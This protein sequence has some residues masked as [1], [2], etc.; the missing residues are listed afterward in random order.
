MK[1]ASFVFVLL[2]FFIW[3]APAYGEGPVEA[4]KVKIVV[5]GDALLGQDVPL[6]DG[7]RILLPLRLLLL[8]LGVQDDDEHIVWNADEQSVTVVKDDSQ[9]YLK[10]G[11]DLA[12]V[13]GES[14]KLDAAPLLHKTGKTYIPV[15]F[16]SQ[17]LG[18]KVAWEPLTET[19]YI[20]DEQDYNE[21]EDLL[22][23]MSEVRQSRE[24]VKLEASMNVSLSGLE[25]DIVTSARMTASCDKAS[26]KLLVTL[27]VPLFSK[28]YSFVTY[29]AD[30]FRH[31]YNPQDH[32]WAKTAVTENEFNEALDN[33]LN[34]LALFR[35][36]VACAGMAVS[37]ENGEII[38]RG[39]VFPEGF[40][41]LISESAGLLTRYD[42]GRYRTE[43]VIDEESYE[44]KRMT[45]ELEG[46][47]TGTAGTSFMRAHIEYAYSVPDDSF[48]IASPEGIEN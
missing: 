48:E 2:L 36:E 32:S 37:R 25:Q 44:A 40:A 9:V 38:L 34:P 33:N 47:V 27:D 1:K 24:K 7:G 20:R 16:V 45:V 42:I 13:N 5:N 26:E 22:E 18:K 46:E 23:K 8:S 30:G 12:E 19:V 10:I 35:S 39:D 14:V 28:D 43:L 17:A 3:G 6:E 4:E 29:Y 31:E 15:R 11:D 21:I 41:E